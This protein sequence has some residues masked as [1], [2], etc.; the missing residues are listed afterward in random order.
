M[1]K[2]EMLLKKFDDKLKNANG[3]LNTILGI[4][5]EVREN[6]TPEISDRIHNSIIDLIRRRSHSK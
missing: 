3:N 4:A 5:R 1:K 6:S 2:D